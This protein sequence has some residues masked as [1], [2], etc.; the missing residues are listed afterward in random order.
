MS[1]FTH[2]LVG[3]S[4]AGLAPLDKRDRAV[5]AVAAIAPDVDGLGAIVELGTR[6]SD[7]PL[8]WFNDY[9]HVFGHNIG[10]GFLA[11]AIA[12]LVAHRR[13]LAAA[14]AGLSFH[15]HLL[16]DILGARGP[17]GYAWPIPYLLPFSDALQL[18]WSGQWALNAW[19][20]FLITVVLLVFMSF[21][22]WRSGISPL[23]MVSARAN[24]GFV[25]ALRHRFGQ[26]GQP[27]TIQPPADQ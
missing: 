17:D 9:H 22:A 24:D 11:V 7:H 27:Y 14:L 19:P 10:M 12:F 23:E 2:F 20:N 4:I 26:P 1:P 5:V 16:G 18:T 6:Q 8:Q 21:H 13:F 25:Q 15:L 3:W